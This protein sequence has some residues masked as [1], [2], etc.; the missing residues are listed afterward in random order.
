MLSLYKNFIEQTHN[1]M[2]RISTSH[3]VKSVR[4][5]R[6]SSLCFPVFGLNTTA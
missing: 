1:K 4:I 5:Q 2:K 6:F 3:H